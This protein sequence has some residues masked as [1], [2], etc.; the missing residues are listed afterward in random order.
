MYDLVFCVALVFFRAAAKRCFR[1]MLR[2]TS[3]NNVV[4][5][6]RKTGPLSRGIRR[7]R[8]PSGI[9]FTGARGSSCFVCCWWRFAHG[10]TR[11]PP[12]GQGVCVVCIAPVFRPQTRPLAMKKS[13]NC[14]SYICAAMFPTQSASN[15]WKCYGGSVTRGAPKRGAL[16]CPRSPKTDKSV[17][18]EYF[19]QPCEQNIFQ[20][21]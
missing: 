15:P 17:N 6:I 4:V 11:T 20:Y 21:D 14:E 10:G 5:F 18:F 9:G 3:G 8:V 12:P 19:P 1:G 16:T 2:S 13:M 7:V